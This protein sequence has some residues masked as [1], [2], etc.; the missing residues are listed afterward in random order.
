MVLK[1]R[2][3]VSHLYSLQFRF[4]FTTKVLVHGKSPG[5]T[6]R[7]VEK[8]GPSVRAWYKDQTNFRRR[9]VLKNHASCVRQV[10]KVHVVK[11]VSHIPSLI[12]TEPN[13]SN[14]LS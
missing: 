3:R 6:D 2:V 12:T 14:G 11:Q 4:H 7:V 1:G 8:A 5:P 10:V 9:D 13:C